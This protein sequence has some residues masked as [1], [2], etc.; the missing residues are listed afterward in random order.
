MTGIPR[1]AILLLAAALVLYGIAASQGWIR[2]PSLAK[3]DYVGTIDV[4]ADDAKLYRAVPFEWQVTSAA[5]SFKGNDTVH[6]RIDPS[7][8]RT[9]M[10]GWVLLDKAGASIRATRWLSEARLAVGDIKVTALFIA[11]VDKKPGDGLN[12]GCLR[13]DEGIRPGADAPLKL[14]GNPVRE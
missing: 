3:A 5:G 2:D 12:A 1:W 11:P 10:C 13:L 8:E 14:E 4:S 6:V 9:V 7:G